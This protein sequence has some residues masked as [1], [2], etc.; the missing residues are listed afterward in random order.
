MST[1]EPLISALLESSVETLDITH[2][3]FEL[4][5][6]RYNDLGQWLVDR[7]IGD[8]DVYPQGS[9]RLGTVLRPGPDGD[10]DIDLVFLRLLAKQSVTQDELR[11]QARE[12]LLAYIA[13]RGGANGNP[14]LEEKGRCWAL[15]Y[16]DDEFHMDVLPVIPDEEGADDAI[17][18]SDRNLR[19]WQHSNPIGYADWFWAAMGD[20]VDVAR[21]QLGLVLNRDVEDVP[22]W[23]VRTALQRVVQLLKLHRDTFF[24]DNAENKPASILITTLA[25]RAY[26]GEGDLYEAYRKIALSLTDHVE[27]REDQWWVPNPAHDDENF[28]DKWNTHPER[29]QH[30]DV[31][32]R[33]LRVDADGWADRPSGIDEFTESLVTAFGDRPVRAGAARVAK[34]L[35]AASAAGGLGVSASGRVAVASGSERPVRRHEFYGG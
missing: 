34:R 31:W 17:L 5:V 33:Q 14:T 19:E 11:T 12:L 7:G 29:K 1:T 4:A 18:L 13:E 25:T 15:V 8:P 27:T 21:S 6:R 35:A 30:F 23:L 3:Q 10:F 26:G 16:T 22:R 2:E 24:A 20:S 9:F 32:L 28:A